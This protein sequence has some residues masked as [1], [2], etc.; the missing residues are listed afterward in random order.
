MNKLTPFRS[1]TPLFRRPL[2]NEVLGLWPQNWRE[3]EETGDWAPTAELIEKPEAYL[4]KLEVPGIKAEEIDVSFTG[5]L[6]TLR[7]ERRQEEKKEGE[8]Y[9]I[10]ERRYGAFER[11]FTF[12]TPVDA[13]HVEAEIKDGVL[14]IR[15]MK[16]EEGKTA[17]VKVK[18]L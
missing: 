1:M 9:Q 13:T 2:W 17:K 18:T 4:V 11:S 6:L 16:K 15:V 14:T 10:F 3:D 8:H 12:P 5:D 7:G